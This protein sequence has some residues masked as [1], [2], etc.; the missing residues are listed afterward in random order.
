MVSFFTLKVKRTGYLLA[1]K[2]A[3]IGIKNCLN[4][5]RDKNNLD[6]WLIYVISGWLMTIGHIFIWS[7]NQSRSG[8]RRRGGEEDT[9]PDSTHGWLTKPFSSSSLQLYPPFLIVH[10]RLVPFIVL[11]D[12][13]KRKPM[14]VSLENI[15]MKVKIS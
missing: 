1:T 2:I 3:I 12:T 7:A 14:A 11:I 6:L 9:G 10:R 5:R 8:R 4:D 15:N 13:L